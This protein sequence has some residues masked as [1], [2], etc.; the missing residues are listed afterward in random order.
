MCQREFVRGNAESIAKKDSA[1]CTADE[2]V[3]D[4]SKLRLA[5]QRCGSIEAVIREVQ[6]KEQSSR[7]NE[8]RCRACFSEYEEFDKLLEIARS[9]ASTQSNSAEP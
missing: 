5:L 7:F 1:T 6:L 8:E 2:R 9:G 3:L 4:A